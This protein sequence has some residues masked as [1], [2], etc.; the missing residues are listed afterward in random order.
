MEIIGLTGGIASGK[1]TVSEQFA[2]HGWAIIDA[3]AIAHQLT[4]V[5]GKAL[6]LIQEAF[7]VDYLQSDGSLNRRKLGRLV[8]ANP[9]L[10]ET[11]NGIMQPLIRQRIAEKFDQAATAGQSYVV[12][13]APTLF[14]QGYQDDCDQ[15]VVVSIDLG[16]Q[17][18]RLQQRDGFSLAEARQRVASQMP[19]KEK[20]ARADWVIDNSGSRQATWLQVAWLIDHFSMI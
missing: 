8:F 12:L 11:L 19:L 7:G 10:L 18:Q 3:D 14:E 5:G 4:A 13:D 1:S 9:A 15:V 16:T 17:L 20:V 6:P 2:Q